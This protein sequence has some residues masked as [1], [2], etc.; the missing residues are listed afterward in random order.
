MLLL[1]INGGQGVIADLDDGM[2]DG[3]INIDLTCN[4]AGTAWEGFG[5][6]ITALECFQQ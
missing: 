3:F 5:V 4:A 1:Q 2:A 6:D